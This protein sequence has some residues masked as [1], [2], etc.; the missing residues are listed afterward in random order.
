[1][2]TAEIRGCQPQE[3]LCGKGCRHPGGSWWPPWTCLDRG[4]GIRM[5][6]QVLLWLRP[7]ST[8]QLSTVCGGGGAG[9]VGDSSRAPARKHT[10]GLKKESQGGMWAPQAPGTQG[11]MGV[12]GIRTQGAV[13][14]STAG[15]QGGEKGEG[16]RGKQEGGGQSEREEAPPATPNPGQSLMLPPPGSSDLCT[17]H[18]LHGGARGTKGLFHFQQALL[19]IVGPWACQGSLSEFQF[20]Y[21]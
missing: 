4:A 9:R 15:M 8:S 18:A 2:K 14:F 12:K 6:G 1:M 19:L 21:L 7:A 20:S 3:G 16:G 17:S 11:E 10:N 13:S 5:L